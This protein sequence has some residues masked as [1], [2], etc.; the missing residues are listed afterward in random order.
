MKVKAKT[1]LKLV[2]EMDDVEARVLMNLLQ[3]ARR[4]EEKDS[5]VECYIRK[6]VSNEINSYLGG[7]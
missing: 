6:L 1:D 2:L 3:Y 4:T 7:V 5:D